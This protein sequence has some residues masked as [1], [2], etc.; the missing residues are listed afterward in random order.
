MNTAISSQSRPTTTDYTPSIALESSFNGISYS[1]LL[2]HWRS[3]DE[4]EC[5]EVN[6]TLTNRCAA[7]VGKF[8]SFHSSPDFELTAMK[9]PPEETDTSDLNSLADSQ[10]FRH[11]SDEPELSSLAES[12]D[13][14]LTTM[15]L[16]PEDSACSPLSSSSSCNVEPGA[17]LCSDSSVGEDRDGKQI[18]RIPSYS[19]TPPLTTTNLGKPDCELQSS[20]DLKHASLTPPTYKEVN[21]AFIR[22]EVFSKNQVF[23]KKIAFKLNLII[24]HTHSDDIGL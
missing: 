2:H 7:S 18:H 21:D 10:V 17:A 15:K 13:F 12:Q 20:V 3:C 14:N 6:E 16:P 22:K 5:S 4:T 9:F 8:S 11:L 24:K 19:I 1:P 23:L